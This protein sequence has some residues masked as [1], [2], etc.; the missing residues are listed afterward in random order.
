MNVNSPSVSGSPFP[1]GAYSGELPN[2]IGIGFEMPHITEIWHVAHRAMAWQGQFEKEPQ[3]SASSDVAVLPIM[4]NTLPTIVRMNR[5]RSFRIR[6]AK[7]SELSE[8]LCRES[9]LRVR[10]VLFNA[11]DTKARAERDHTNFQYPERPELV[12]GRR[13]RTMNPKSA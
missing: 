10:G 3:G 13:H 8:G 6:D 1:D 9:V 12:A 7:L 11:E 4:A 5:V 2:P